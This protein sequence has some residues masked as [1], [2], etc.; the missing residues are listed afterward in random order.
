LSLIT[1]RGCPFHC[2]FCTI[3][4]VS[5]Q[6]FAARAPSTVADEIEEQV[7]VTGVRPF[8]IEDDNFTFDMERASKLCCEI[9]RRR[10]RHGPVVP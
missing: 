7:R 9:I 3:A 1:G 2:S 4:P 8:A 5:G 10:L 6:R